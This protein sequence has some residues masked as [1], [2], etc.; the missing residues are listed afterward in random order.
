MWLM[1]GRNSV[2]VLIFCMK[3]EM[4]LIVLEMIGS[5]WVL[6][7]LLYFRIKVVILFIK[8]VLLSLVLIIIIV[9]IEMIVLEVRLLNS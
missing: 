6:V 9:M 3:E 1:M 4:M 8:L 2:V 7:L 5:M